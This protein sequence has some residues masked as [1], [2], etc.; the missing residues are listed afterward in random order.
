MLL[1][2]ALRGVEERVSE[3]LDDFAL[4]TALEAIWSRVRRLN[5]YVEETKPWELSKEE[6]AEPDRPRTRSGAGDLDRVLY[7]LAEGVRVLALALLPYT[8]E[9]AAKVLDAL[10]EDSRR[11]AAFGSRGGGAKV[12]RIPPLFPKLEATE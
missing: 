5:R 4:T 9:T 1:D 11:L 3:L 7:N 2:D 8:P 12:E 6:L 10:G